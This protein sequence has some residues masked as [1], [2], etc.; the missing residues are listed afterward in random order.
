MVASHGLWLLR[1]CSCNRHLKV[2]CIATCW[3]LAAGCNKSSNAPSAPQNAPSAPQPTSHP[4]PAPRTV[5]P[6]ITSIEPE[7]IEVRGGHASST[8][9]RVSYSIDSPERVTKAM[10]RIYAPGI[11]D[12]QHPVDVLVRASDILDFTLD[13]SEDFG[14]KVS[15]RVHCPAGDTDW[16][17]FG[18]PPQPYDPEANGKIKISNV[19][20]RYVSSYNET[21]AENSGTLVTIWA[22]DMITSECTAET[23]VDGHAV[24]LK[25]TNTQHRQMQGLLMRSDVQQRSIA[26]RYLEFKL[27]LEGH[28]VATEAIKQ[29][30]FSE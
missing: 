17:T 22:G 11:G 10:L 14:P 6:R 29:V 16:Y 23:E 5:A 15:F 13:T 27:I 30:P 4:A 3:I 18:S 25:N 21:G 26:A 20:P 24:E 12:V 19:T 2:F 7:T 9:F 28:G 8:R 1:N